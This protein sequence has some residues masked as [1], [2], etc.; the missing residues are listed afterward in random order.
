MP[1]LLALAAAL[2]FGIGDFCGGRAARH[3]RPFAVTFLAQSASLVA[4]L[5]FVP[6]ADV[7][8][9]PREVLL[10]G[11]AAGVSGTLAAVTLYPAL[12]LGSASEVAPLS[13]L[14]G[15]AGPVLFGVLL[16][17]R[18]SGRAWAGIALAAL[19]IMLV[20]A[21][22]DAN[23][24]D[25]ARRRRA[26]VLAFLSGL[27]ISTF[28]VCFERASDGHGLVPL[29]AARAT[30][31]AL[32]ALAFALLRQNPLP[33]APARAITLLSGLADTGA[34]AGYVLALASAPLATTATLANLYPAVT[35]LCGVFVLGD[36]P[37]PIQQAGLVL[38]LGAIALIT[39]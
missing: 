4:L 26:L 6:V 36:R 11:A 27:F 8:G 14:V 37:R 3:G 12:A 13:A 29:L 20:S 10:W 28:L 34:N 21:A 33:P 22:G 9:A 25:P 30:S 16:G 15:T 31:L 19:T 1:T 32:L 39:R 2:L 7:L 23:A 24:T 17:E 35:V 5:L 38:A 18:P